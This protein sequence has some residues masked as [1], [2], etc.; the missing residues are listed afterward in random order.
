MV[1]RKKS[2]LLQCLSAIADP[3]GNAKRRDLVDVLVMGVCTIF[4]EVQ[5][6]DE[7][8]ESVWVRES[9]ARRFLWLQAI[10]A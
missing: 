10:P 7:M 2:N 6:F 8:A 5:G 1:S 9:R 3:W 4:A